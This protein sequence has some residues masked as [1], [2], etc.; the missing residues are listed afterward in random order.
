MSKQK[1]VTVK[2]N[3]TRPEGLVRKYANYAMVNASGPDVSIMFCDVMPPTNSS[4]AKLKN[5][6]EYDVPVHSEIVMPQDVAKG[7]VNAIKTQM[8]LQKEVD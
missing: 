8:N 4:K 1:Q 3:P 2:I 6:Q 7:L 5:N